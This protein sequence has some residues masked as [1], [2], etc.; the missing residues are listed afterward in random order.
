MTY[1]IRFDYPEGTVYAGLHKGA[2][3]WA[4]TVATALLFDDADKARA[5]LTNAYGQ[6]AEWGKVVPVRA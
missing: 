1:A 2:A 3:G 6:S 5:M 4:P